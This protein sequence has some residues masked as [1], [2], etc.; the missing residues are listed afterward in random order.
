[1]ARWIVAILLV[2]LLS[3]EITPNVEPRHGEEEVVIDS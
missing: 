2:L 1:M 3:V